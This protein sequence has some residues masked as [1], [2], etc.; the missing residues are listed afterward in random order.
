MIGGGRAACIVAALWP[1]RVSGLVSCDK[2]YNIQ[3]I[4][5]AG[6]PVAPEMEHRLWYQYYFHSERGRAALIAD[7]RGLCRLLWR[8]W[9]PSWLFDVATF[10]RSAEAFDNPD[11]VE[12]VVQSYRHRFGLVAGD[13]A[14]AA[15]EGPPYRPA[16]DQGPEYPARGCG[17]RREPANAGGS[18]CRPFHRA[19]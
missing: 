8:L 14:F 12:V 4:A 16:S 9:S 3:N 18:P 6:E 11:F 5:K 10:E 17:R 15:I 19:L 13:P 7:R 1:E 2:G